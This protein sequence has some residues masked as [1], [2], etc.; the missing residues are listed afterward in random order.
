MQ[1]KQYIE[2][3]AKKRFRQNAGA[4]HGQDIEAMLTEVRAN[5]HPITYW[6]PAVG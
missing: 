4:S 1:E 5:V 2:A 6:L 3:E